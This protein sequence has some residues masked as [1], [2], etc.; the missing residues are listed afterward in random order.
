MKYSYQTL[1]TIHNALVIKAGKWQMSGAISW[2]M[3]AEITTSLHLLWDFKV[4]LKEGLKKVGIFS[5]REGGPFRFQ[6]LFP[7]F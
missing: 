4:N 7:L 5:L 6:L 3:S 1:V 2:T